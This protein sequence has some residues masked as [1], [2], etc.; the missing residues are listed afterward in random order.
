MIRARA[1]CFEGLDP[2]IR[3]Q[4]NAIEGA[5]PAT[6]LFAICTNLFLVQCREVLLNCRVGACSVV[7]EDLQRRKLVVI[8]RSV[9]AVARLVKHVTANWR[10]KGCDALERNSRSQC[11]LAA[12]EPVDV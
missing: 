6:Y 9:I 12:C 5:A 4:D 7:H 1:Y 10:L 3:C 8:I 2:H 11:N